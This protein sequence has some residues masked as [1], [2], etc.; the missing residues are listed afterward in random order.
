[1]LTLTSMRKCIYK[2]AVAKSDE[3]KDILEVFSG[4]GF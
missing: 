2:E 3:P 1:V 4:M